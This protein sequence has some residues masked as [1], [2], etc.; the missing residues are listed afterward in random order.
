M[1]NN[2]KNENTNKINL[3]NN[4]EYIGFDND[5]NDLVN[6]GK[7]ELSLISSLKSEKTF[8]KNL[9]LIDKDWLLLWKNK[10]GYNQIKNQIFK[11]L[12]YKQ[13]NRNYKEEEEKLNKVWNEI[14]SRNDKEAYPEIKNKKYLLHV[15][16]KTLINGKEKFDI[17][18]S[19]IQDLF[20]KFFN[21]T[22]II[23]VSGLFCKKKLLLPFNYNDKN[24]N[25]I[26]I[27]MLFLLNNKNDIGEILFEFPNLK[28]N[29]IEK[30]RKE[31]SNKN[32][33]EFI[34]DFI[35]EKN[36]EYIFIDEDG[37]KYTYKAFPKNEK[38]LL[39][40]NRNINI[41]KNENRSIKY[42]MNE[43]NYKGE[44]INNNL[45]SNDILNFDID[46]MTSEQIKEKI[47]KI[48]E[49]TLKQ[50]ELEKYLKEQENLLLKESGFIINEDEIIQDDYSKYQEQIKE[51]EYKIKN[52]K[53]EIKQCQ[54]KENILNKEFKKFTSDFDIKESQVNKKL[55]ELNDKETQIKLKLEE[56]NSIENNLNNKEK[57]L[58]KKEEEFKKEENKNNKKREEHKDIK[59]EINEKIKIL[60]N[61]ENLENERMNKELEEEMKELENQIKQNKKSSKDMAIVDEDEDEELN[62]S[63]DYVRNKNNNNI[64]YKKMKSEQTNHP[65]LKLNKLNSQS[66]NNQK[67][68][69][70]NSINSNT[71]SNQ[72]EIN[73][74]KDRIS[75]PNLNLKNK[76]FISQNSDEIKEKINI[77]KNIIS[78]GLE[79]MNPVNLN[80]IIQCFL[81]LKEIT[82]GILNLE[83]NKFFVNNKGCVL[84]QNYLILIKK[85]FFPEN[86]DIFSLND[87]WN[88][89]KNKDKKNILSKNKLYI[90]LK[91][92]IKF[93]IEELHHELNT[94]KIFS[95]KNLV[96]GIGDNSESL[97]E[98]ESLCKCLEEF[99][100]NNNS[101]ISKNFY[102]LLKQKSICQV[103]KTEIY[104]FKFYT[105]LSFNLSQVKN[106]ILKEKSE[107]NKNKITIKLLD[108]FDY[109]N[110]PEYLIGD[111]GLFCKKCKSKNNFTILKSI[112]SSHPII[113]IIIE[114]EDN[115][116]LNKDKIDFPEELDLSKYLEYKP[117]SRKFFLCGVVTNFGY[118]NNFGKFEAF[119]KMEQ[120]G[121]WLNYNDEQVSESDW[122]DIHKNGIV[123]VLFYHKI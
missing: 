37:I 39:N 61:E 84:S 104:N 4:N 26:F 92:L 27:N 56:L 15:N 108:C 106:F 86:S 72:E 3:T 17:I 52:S 113:P 107:K 69:R 70:F 33:S 101:L 120:K 64:K 24:V 6:Y 98:K 82:E 57:D 67:F 29:I 48:E 99:T 74:N 34:K 91:D 5:L 95:K 109:Y 112:Y 90:Y 118:S 35:E 110:K 13:K 50:I 14:K 117:S 23:K 66:I 94:K 40:P 22:Q 79:K 60:K 8:R 51:M 21:K 45:D 41:K 71:N 97:N 32:I 19:D 62:N 59:E 85:L 47:K 36:K 44:K 75:L 18:S 121:K 83:K 42:S 115:S 10:S 105:F 58:N 11:Y 25:Y 68:E 49:E 87:F 65:F 119:C 1:N 93:L 122:E 46:K 81:H 73:T 80:S 12:I 53:N 63:F 111:L 100:K 88:C 103:C 54:D 38:N 30:I 96:N 123:Y 114:R 7:W 16:N 76:I 2:A 102:G 31:I 78:S 28:L 89:L 77:D 43:I 116:K 20:Q 9:L 55:M